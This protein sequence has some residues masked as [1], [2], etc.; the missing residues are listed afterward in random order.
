MIS[1]QSNEM[2]THF[3]GVLRQV[4]QEQEFLIT[5]HKKT[6]ASLVPYLPD[7]IG[8][9]DPILILHTGGSSFSINKVKKEISEGFWRKKQNG[10]KS[11]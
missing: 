1:I 8:A 11:N 7:S 9:M 6:V 5:K 10:W 2:K 3:S 4:E